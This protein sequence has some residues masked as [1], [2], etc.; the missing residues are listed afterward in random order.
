M[1][2]TIEVAT[3]RVVETCSLMF[4]DET[5]EALRPAIARHVQQLHSSGVQDEHR[6][7][8]S[9]LRDLRRPTRL[10]AAESDQDFVMRRRVLMI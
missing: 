6:L 8:V 9:V 4:G 1:H 2:N 7:A 5:A 3:R 10:G